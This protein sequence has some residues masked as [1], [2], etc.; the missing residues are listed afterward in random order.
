[1]SPETPQFKQV[2]EQLAADQA[3][4][5]LVERD[6]GSIVPGQVMVR[7]EHGARV[8][9]ANLNEEAN[10]R[11][12][13]TKRVSAEKLS[14][15]HQEALAEKLAGVALRGVEAEAPKEEFDAEAA[16]LERSYKEALVEKSRAQQE[17]R[18]ED[19]TYWGQVAGQALLE[20]QKKNK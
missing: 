9:M 13:Q 17:G 8:F 4:T 18:G 14:D 1:M 3:A 15:E 10:D 16:N 5:V 20:L 6:N 7:G 19:S 11:V 2:D 12:I